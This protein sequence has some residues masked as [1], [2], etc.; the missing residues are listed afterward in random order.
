MK[1]TGCLENEDRRPK[2]EDPSKKKTPSKTKTPWKR[3]P[4]RKRRP[5]R[6]RRPLENEDP[7]KTKT[8]R[9]RRPTRKRRPVE[10]EDP[11]KTKTPR[12]R[13]PPRKTYQDRIFQQTSIHR[14][15]RSLIRLKFQLNL[16]FRCAAV[17]SCC[18]KR[19]AWPQCLSCDRVTRL[20]DYTQSVTRSHDKHWGHVWRF[21]Q[22]H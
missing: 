15:Q 13:R 19:R 3:R 16:P 2:T 5:T 6:K 7:S 20:I 17:W 9:K 12:K 4:P 10:N 14:V 21:E 11:S 8:P 18:S 22:Q 1:E